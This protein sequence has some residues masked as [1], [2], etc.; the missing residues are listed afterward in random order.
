MSKSQ[1]DPFSSRKR[2]NK[3]KSTSL[4]ALTQNRI[5]GHPYPGSLYPLHILGVRI[6]TIFIF[7]CIKF[8]ML[9][10]FIMRGVD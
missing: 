1:A 4:V 7:I 10:G 3:Q 9:L 5:A 6:H 2:I 8:I